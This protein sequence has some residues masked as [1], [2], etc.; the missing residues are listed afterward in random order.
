MCTPGLFSASVPKDNSADLARQEEAARQGRIQQG[1]QSIDQA[2]SGFDDPYYSNYTKTYEDNYNPQLTTQYNDAYRKLV[3]GL[4]H[5][6]NLSSSEGAREIGDL[7]RTYGDSQAQIANQAVSATNA[8]RGNVEGQRANLLQMNT[9]AADPSAAGANATAALSGLQAPPT[10]SP[11]GDAFASIIGSIPQGVAAE[12][13]GSRGFGTGL[14][15]Q[16]K[17]SVTVVS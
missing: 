9:Q 13:Q 3:L 8:L 1:T 10:Y 7:K 17:S 6:G 15:S 14:F 11:L 5:S 16:P 2:F 4:S 12:Q